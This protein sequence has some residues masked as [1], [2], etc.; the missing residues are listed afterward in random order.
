M[1]GIQPVAFAQTAWDLA[2]AT[3]SL[4]DIDSSLAFE[5]A[6]LYGFQR[7]YTGLTE[8]MLRAMYVRPPSEN[9]E[10]F[11][12]TLRVYLDDIVGLEPEMVKAYAK[13]LPLIDRALKD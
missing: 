6:A 13:I 11:L 7:T 4:A 1:K 10:P 9:L 8:G 5:L 3:Q 12:H 2:I